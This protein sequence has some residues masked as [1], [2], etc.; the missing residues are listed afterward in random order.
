MTT[1]AQ[2]AQLTITLAADQSVE[3][4][5]AGLAYVDLVAGAPGSPHDSVRVDAG[6][7]RRFG[8]Y[9]NG[10]VVKVRA[11]QGAA[12]VLSPIVPWGQ[13][14]VADVL[15][16]TGGGSRRLKIVGRHFA[17][18]CSVGAGAGTD[19]GGTT[20]RVHKAISPLSK[21]AALLGTHFWINGGAG[22][23]EDSSTLPRNF[24][25]HKVGF[26]V[27]G[28]TTMSLL[29]GRQPFVIDPVSPLVQTDAAGVGV[30]AGGTFYS[31]LYI[32]PALPPSG[33]GTATAVAGGSLAAATYYYTVTRTENGVE[34]GPIAEFS[35]TTAASNLTL[36][37][38]WVDSRSATA[39]FYT[40]YR[41][42]ATAGTKQYLARTSGPQKRLDDDG[43]YVVDTTINPPAA[44]NYRFN[45]V[46][47]ATGD[48]TNHVNGTGD[49]SDQ[50]SAAGTFGNAGPAYKF[51]TAPQCVVGD[52]TSGKSVLFLGDSIGGGRGFPVTSGKYSQRINLLD[53]AF[54]DGAYHS[55]NAA[56]NGTTLAELISATQPGGGRSRLLLIQ[57]ADWVFDQHGTNDLAVGATFV[58][59][60]TNKLLLARVCV[61]A[62]AK[63]ATMTIPPRVTSTDNCLTIGGQTKNAIESKRL[64]FNQWC[65]NG[66]QV[67]DAGLP[68]ISGGTP[69]PHVSGVIDIA[70][71]VEVDASNAPA[72]DGGYWAVP[73]TPVA[74][75]IVATGV[76][77]TTSIPAAGGGFGAANDHV[78]RVI[79]VTSGARAGQVAVVSANTA[80]GFSIYAN[81]D[82]SMSGISVTGLSA[83]P[84]AGDTFDVY[85]VLTDEGLHPAIAGH[86]AM[87]APVQGFLLV[88]IP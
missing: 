14:Q 88:N 3:V 2:D 11:V 69:S 36:R 17:F 47:Y 53:L 56:Y 21:L 26:E 7:S 71:A 78:S 5:T 80:V 62:G 85:D 82:T 18:N 43:G 86:Y 40:A 72:F 55:C 83:A 1:V 65:R 42:A 79:K 37:L 22:A 41:S 23:T 35:G 84:A 87:S 64:Q 34:S 51:G 16:L 19:L 24:A 25:S 13:P 75:G 81:G 10:A 31:R 38:A 57:Y 33:A 27:G 44:S 39:D 15:A 52:D 45:Q 20:R 30:A 67:D 8:P 49:G 70:S 68:V 66:C 61:Q 6:V 59:L 73:I 58:A 4:A 63:F 74:A 76:P 29:N 48:A 28:K 46:T 60:A 54:A 12:N 9:G 77:T 32:K 50:S